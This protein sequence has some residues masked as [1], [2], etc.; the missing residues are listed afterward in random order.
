MHKYFP[1]WSPDG[2]ELFYQQRIGN[3]QERKSVMMG[4]S[5]KVSGHRN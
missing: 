2:E 5:Y 3:Q 4:Q 1:A